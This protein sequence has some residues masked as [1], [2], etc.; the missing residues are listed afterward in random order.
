MKRRLLPLLVL[1]P[2]LIQA[3]DL[4]ITEILYNLP[5][6]DDGEYIEIFHNGN[7]AINL[8]GYR[9]RARSNSSSSDIFNYTLPSQMLNPGEFL[10]LTDDATQFAAS[11][12]SALSPYNGVEVTW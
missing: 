10:L 11:F 6:T 8:D 2:F 1:L 12:G 3:Q 9:V 7:A 4:V 5:G